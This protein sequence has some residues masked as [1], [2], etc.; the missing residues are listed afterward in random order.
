LLVLPDIDSMHFVTFSLLV[1][2]LQLKIGL[3][4]QQGLLRS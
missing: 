4:Y 3:G 2:R 1:K